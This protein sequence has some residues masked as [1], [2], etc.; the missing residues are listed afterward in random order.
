MKIVI[1]CNN[2]ESIIGLRETAFINQIIKKTTNL[3][4]TNNNMIEIVTPSVSKTIKI[5][6]VEKR[7]RFDQRRKPP[8]KVLGIVQKLIKH[9]MTKPLLRRE[10]LI[11]SPLLPLPTFLTTMFYFPP[12]HLIFALCSARRTSAF[13]AKLS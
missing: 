6:E 5:T 10:H 7:N 1:V 2:N 11:I 13:V 4:L 8:V 3:K 9:R 12:S